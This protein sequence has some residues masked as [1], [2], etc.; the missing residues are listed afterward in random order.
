[1]KRVLTVLLVLALAVSIPLS[2]SFAKSKKSSGGWLGVY[3]ESVDYDLSDDLDLPVS[4]GAYI[5]DI[6]NDSP[7][8]EAGLESDDVVIAFNGEKVTDSDDL[9]DFVMDGKRGDKVT[10]SIIRDGKEK[11]IEVTLGKSWSYGTRRVDVHNGHDFDFDFD[12]DRFDDAMDNYDDALEMYVDCNSGGYIGVYL[13]S[14]SDPLREYFGVDEGLGV[15]VN[16]TEEDSPAEEA[17]LKAGDVIF[18]ADGE[19]IEDSGDLR[20]VISEFDEG[21]KVKIKVIRDKNKKE[22]TVEI[23]ERDSHYNYSIF[24][25][26]DDDHIII[27]PCGK[28]HLRDKALHKFDIDKI[29]RIKKNRA[30]I[31]LDELREI[32]DEELDD[33]RDEMK[34]LKRELK[35]LYK[36]LDE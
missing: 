28:I 26:D 11:E 27:S 29:K 34:E 22:F 20:E 5:A 7:A 33:L 4:Y 24:N 25:S 3:L 16:G 32:E 30:I 17:G 12:F 19:E 23:A 13:T 15:L 10:L 36:K 18:E 31:N 9:T 2:F 35:E 21:D 6:V 14:L 1:M 8:E